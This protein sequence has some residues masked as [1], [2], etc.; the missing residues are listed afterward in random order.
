MGPRSADRGNLNEL[1]EAVAER[2]TS[3][4]P[5]S[6]DRGNTMCGFG[7]HP[8]IGLQWGRDQL[9]AEICTA[10]SGGAGTGLLQWGRDQLI[11]EII[12]QELAT[13]RL[14]GTSMG[15]RS[16]D[17]GND[18]YTEALWHF[19]LQLQWGRDQLIA[20]MQG[21]IGA[22]KP[23]GDTSMGPRSADRGNQYQTNQGSNAYKLQWG[24][25]QLIAEIL[26]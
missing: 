8:G 26:M 17:R 18:R 10:A 22:S 9:I 6:A 4:G 25:D 15:P 2:V 7:A 11:A 1:A 24:R 16:A 5:R 13:Y 20:E 23:H 14:G 21:P 19:S 3:M 12:W